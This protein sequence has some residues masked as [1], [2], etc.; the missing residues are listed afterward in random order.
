MRY[1]FKLLLTILYLTVPVALEVSVPSF[2]QCAF[3]QSSLRR[4]QTAQKLFEQGNIPAA[5]KTLRSNVRRGAK[6][7]KYVKVESLKLYG[8][9]QYLLGKQRAAKK[10]FETAL[11]LNSKTVL[12]RQ[13]I[14]DPQ[15]ATVF[16]NI[17]SKLNKK[18]KSGLVIKTNAKRAS[19]YVDNVFR[20]KV[21]KLLKL[22]KGRYLI[23]VVA[24]GYKSKTKKVRVKSGT[25]RITI[26]L[27]KK[28]RP[29]KRRRSRGR[30]PSL[31]YDD[32]LPTGSR[33]LDEAIDEGYDTR[34]RRR[35]PRRRQYPPQQGYQQQPPPPQNYPPPQREYP[36]QQGPPPNYPQ[37]KSTGSPIIAALPLGAGQFQNGDYFKGVLFAGAQIGGVAFAFFNIQLEQGWVDYQAAPDPNGPSLED[38][39][40]AQEEARLGQYIGWGIAAA[41]YGLGVFEAFY[42]MGEQAGPAPPPPP[43]QQPYYTGFV[44][45]FKK[46][47]GFSLKIDF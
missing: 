5:E 43:Q 44:N 12:K 17:R 36:P 40:A 38:A 14:L 26:R 34:G 1:L 32:D 23:K 47:F 45:P 18:K 35:A 28:K 20:G 19:L 3:A 6:A 8:V 29:K 41:A 31:A 42:T 10:T 27:A 4:L 33:S 11:K 2:N 15:I 30:D 7:N 39:V 16:S 13:Y 22:K 25:N 37:A 9:C 24:P 21:G 46:S